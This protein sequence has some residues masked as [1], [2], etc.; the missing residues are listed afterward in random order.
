MPPVTLRTQFTPEIFIE[1]RNPRL[2][3]HDALP[4]SVLYF[5]SFFFFADR[6]SQYNLSN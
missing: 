6:A 2:Q 1:L 4:L 5:R 3:L